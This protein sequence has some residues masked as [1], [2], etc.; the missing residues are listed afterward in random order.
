MR[1]SRWTSGLTRESKNEIIS[2]STEMDSTVNK[3]RV[4]RLYDSGLFLRKGRQ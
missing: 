1:M 4:N 2:A 3:I